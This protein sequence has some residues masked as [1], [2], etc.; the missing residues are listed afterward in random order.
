MNILK[1]YIIEIYDESIEIVD[2]V[3]EFAVVDIRYVCYGR[4]EREEREIR[5]FTKQ[6]WEEIKKQGF[7]WA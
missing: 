7:F 4:E 3:V 5:H 6:A 2:D 1:H